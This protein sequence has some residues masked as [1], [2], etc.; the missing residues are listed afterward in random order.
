MPLRK[1]FVGQREVNDCGVACLAMAA[2]VDYESAKL[3]FDTLGLG[4]KNHRRAGAGQASF[5]E[6]RHHKPQ[7]RPAYSSNFEELRAAM[8]SL[9]LRSSMKRFSG[10]DGVRGPAVIKVSNGHKSNWHWVFANRSDVGLYVLDP[11]TNLST[12]PAQE[13]MTT[14]MDVSR[15]QPKGCF[16]EIHAG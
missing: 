15:H 9:G 10:W 13:A 2:R 5:M 1:E 6:I 14:F 12:M 16:I 7:S 3:I 4:E 11:L 8:N